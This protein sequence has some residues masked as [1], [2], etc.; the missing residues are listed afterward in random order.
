MKNIAISFFLILTLNALA[1]EK[2]RFNQN[3]TFKILQFTDTH[4]NPSSPTSAQTLETMRIMIQKENP[5]FVVVTGDIVTADPADKGWHQIADVM[6][7]AQTPWTVTFGNHDEEHNLTKEEIFEILKTKPYFYGTKGESSGVLNFDLPIYNAQNEEI[8]SVL[9]FVDSHDYVHNPILGKYDWIKSDQIDWY[10][11]QS[12][13][14][15]ES[16]G[17]QIP[18]M[19]F[20]HIPLLEYNHIADEAK[21]LGEKL[22]GIA[23]P[24][25]NSGLFSAII[26]QKDVMGIFCGHDHNNNYVGVHKNVALAFGNV[27]GA[28]AYGELERGARVIVLQ[29]NKFSFHTYISTPTQTKFPFN[30]PSG[31]TE[32]QNNTKVLKALN[33]QPKK[34]GLQYVYYE[35]EIDA[36]DEIADLEPKK[37]GII[38]SFD[39]GIAEAEDHFA[40]KY[41][42]YI[43]IPETAFYKFYTYSDDGTI[44]KIDNQTV[45]NN[46]GGH[47]PRRKE[48]VVA[49]EKGFHKLELLYFED[50]M[51]QI[52]DVGFSGIAIPEQHL[53]AYLYHE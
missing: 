12:Q 51:G 8:A 52:L 17:R 33:I 27:T 39:I 20:F 42:G 46:D 9:Y 32:I 6:V 38:Q 41:D 29:P 19:M 40:L 14:Y 47:S 1:Q 53:D 10:R 23:S 45:V 43:Y 11:K 25:V 5:D 35:G 22:E 50:Y 13:K 21:T 34:Q 31:L 28:D 26:E 48:G 44:L 24:E 30:F 2:L 37:S 49:L 3:D 7:K 36:T 18:S 15:M 4:H 16:N